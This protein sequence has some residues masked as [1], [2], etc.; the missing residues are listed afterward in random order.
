MKTLPG[1]VNRET[2]LA[3]FYWQL[4]LLRRKNHG[5]KYLNQAFPTNLPEKGVY[6][7]FEKGIHTN[8]SGR[9]KVMRIGTHGL[10]GGNRTLGQRLNL[11]VNG[12]HRNSV[13]RKHVGGAIIEQMD[14][15]IP[16]WGNQIDDEVLFVEALVNEYIA[17]CPYTYLAVEDAGDR[18][19]IEKCSI[20]ILSNWEKRSQI[21]KPPDTWLGYS[22]KSRRV[23]DSHLWNVQH[24]TRPE[25]TNYVREYGDFLELFKTLVGHHPRL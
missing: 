19:E 9:L 24:T 5:F 25:P 20:E 21:N 22:C 6:F 12:N 16:Q 23:R 17:A 3:N 4:L 11:H 18:M 13:F 2:F 1:P 8:Y 10:Q 15:D 14:L 7:F